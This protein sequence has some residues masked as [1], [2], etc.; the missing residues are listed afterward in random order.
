MQSIRT[1]YLGASP[2]C[3]EFEGQSPS[4]E[5][6]GNAIYLTE[7]V[8][9]NGVSGGGSDPF[10][11]APEI[12]NDYYFARPSITSTLPLSASNFSPSCAT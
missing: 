2:L 11:P 4:S 12:D 8:V 6:I 3:G 10:R 5:E 1:G 7:N 9:G